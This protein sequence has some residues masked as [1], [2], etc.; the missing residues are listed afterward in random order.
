MGLLEK[1]LYVLGS[2]MVFFCELEGA[3]GGFK[4]FGVKLA[5]CLSNETGERVRIQGES[6]G[7][8]GS[9]FLLIDLRNVLVRMSNE[10]EALRFVPQ[11][12]TRK[13]SQPKRYR[14]HPE[15]SYVCSQPP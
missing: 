3:D 8:V 7:T 1:T 14:T 6:F 11:C 15:N 2:R 4:V 9:C 13:P 10:F 5:L 12:S